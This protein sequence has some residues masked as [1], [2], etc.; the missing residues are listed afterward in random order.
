MWSGENPEYPQ[1]LFDAMKDN[2]SFTKLVGNVELSDEKPWFLSWFGE[3]LMSL[4]DSTVFGT[5]LAKVVDLLCEELQHERFGEARV[6]I[7]LA[8]VRVS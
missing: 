5:V 8:A 7:M 4:R 6:K 2:P 1:I 3:Y